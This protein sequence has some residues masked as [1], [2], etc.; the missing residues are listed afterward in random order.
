MKSKILILDNKIYSLSKISNFL[1]QKK[2]EVV[3]P[4]E[5]QSV[6]N[7]CSKADLD[8]VIIDLRLFGEKS[9]IF[10]QNLKE[11]VLPENVKLI[12]ISDRTST[13][14]IFDRIATDA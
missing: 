13:H 1:K 2:F 9:N 11:N 4:T 10:I 3:K 12:T 8:A 6:F 5:T 7:I 14:Q